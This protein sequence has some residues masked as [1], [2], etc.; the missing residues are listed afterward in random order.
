MDV[1]DCALTFPI[2]SHLQVLIY[3]LRELASHP[4]TRHALNVRW[5]SSLTSTTHTLSVIVATHTFS[6][7][8]CTCVMYMLYD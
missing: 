2:R 5:H 1:I 7:G 8:D 4:A 3:G 6:Y